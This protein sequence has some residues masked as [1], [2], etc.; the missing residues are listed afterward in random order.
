MTT[1]QSIQAIVAHCKAKLNFAAMVVDE[2]F[3]QHLPACIVDTVFSIG[4]RYTSTRNTVERFCTQLGLPM[5]GHTAQ[6]PTV[7]QFSVSDFLKLYET[8]DADTLA[9]TLYQNRQR[10]SPRNG[11]LK[12]AAAQQ[13]A[14]VLQANKIEYLQDVDSIIGH[15]AFEDAIQ[16][17]QGHASGISLRYF[18][19]L[20]GSPNHVKPDRMVQR[21][22]L[23]ATG[24]S[25][26][27][28]DAEHSIRQASVSL[29]EEY[30][31]LTPALLDNLIWRYQQTQRSAARL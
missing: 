12:A 30:P 9:A 7:E 20:V 21:F 16:Q 2:Q 22:L 19:I 10:T 11:I 24:H 28:V 14:Q 1:D 23:T 31:L 4:A 8:H 18:Y 3:Y 6:P 13:F 27:V 5:L 15:A 26:D 29:R 17:I 25:F